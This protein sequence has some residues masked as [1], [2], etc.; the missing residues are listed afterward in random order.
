M[1]TALSSQRVRS[2][3]RAAFDWTC[4]TLNV[5]V[6][7]PAMMGT[8]P[9]SFVITASRLLSAA[10]TSAVAD[11]LRLLEGKCAQDY[12]PKFNDNHVLLKSRGCPPSWGGRSKACISQGSATSATSRRNFLRSK[13]LVTSR[14]P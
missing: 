10:G 5:E 4:T 12:S 14:N 9:A 11:T 1:S 6:S 3:S 2:D 8:T 7:A 13:V